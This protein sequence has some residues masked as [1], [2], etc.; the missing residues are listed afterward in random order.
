[1]YSN[2]LIKLTAAGLL[3]LTLWIPSLTYS[4]AVSHV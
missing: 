4:G 3:H 1:M 2:D